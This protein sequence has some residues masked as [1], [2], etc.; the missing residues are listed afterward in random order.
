MG[1]NWLGVTR[2][3]RHTKPVVDAQPPS[4][5]SRRVSLLVCVALALLVLAVYG[6][7]GGFEFVNLD[8]EP[9]VRHNPHVRAGLTLQGIAWAFTTFQQ[10]NYHPL[11]WVSLMFDSQFAGT[12]A[13]FYHLHNLALHL[14]AT[15]L[16]FALLNRMTGRLYRSAFVAALFAVHPLHVESVAWV[17]ERKD[18]LSAVF[19]MLTTWLYVRHVERPGLVRFVP[20]IVAYAIGLLAKPML[21]TLPLTLLL[22]DY[23]PLRRSRVFVLEKT[24][25]F[26]LSAASCIV[27]YLAQRAGGSVLPVEAAGLSARLG[28]ALVSYVA[29]V[30]KMVWPAKLAMFYPLAFEGPPGW[31]AALSGVALAAATVVAVRW[32]RLLPFVF[33]GWTWY[34][35]TLVPVLGLVQVGSQAMADRYTYIPL[36]GLFL[37][38]AWG[39]PELV[40][41]KR[42][43][44]LAVAAVAIVAALSVCAWYQAGYWRNSTALAEH[45]LAAMPDNYVAHFVLGKALA[46]KGRTD[47]AV[48]HYRTAL[49]INPNCEAA[50]AALGGV[51][52]DRGDVAG[53]V[54]HLRRATRISPGTAIYHANL[55]RA[56]MDSGDLEG[57]VYEIK[58]ALRRSPRLIAARN[59]L[60]YTLIQ[61]GRVDEAQGHCEKVLST[62]PRSSDA[63]NN[64]GLIALQRGDLERAGA[65]F[66]TALRLDPKLA[67]AHNN[68]GVVFTRQ[69]RVK[70]A[71]AEFAAA[72]RQDPSQDYFRRNL[73]RARA[74]VKGKPA[75]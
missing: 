65:H 30:I 58:E 56:L 64:L 19:W 55:G 4:P 74:L 43:R 7:V 53:A 68:L 2:I 28:N 51:L 46:D 47:E 41:P 49:S 34:L 75:R 15:L 52:L 70:E 59:N 10:S 72:V 25:L 36:I 35:V 57:A 44:P 62:A 3:P 24:P 6:Q 38:I 42:T 54:E 39:A 40:S 32:R 71:V 1:Y 26:V 23:W 66:R 67:E 12:R 8:D 27:T 73:D 48:E 9:Y 60:A 11:T 37:A 16:I 20:V 69:N 5:Q 17:S 61:L 13:G 14:V 31:K 45:A 21:V 18:V 29:Y 50:C 63:F 33:V 22:L